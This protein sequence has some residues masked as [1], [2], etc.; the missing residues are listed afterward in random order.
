MSWVQ[1]LLKLVI[2]MIMVLNFV[3][4][5]CF[6]ISCLIEEVVDCLLI[7]IGL[8]NPIEFHGSFCSGLISMSIPK[9]LSLNLRFFKITIKDSQLL[10]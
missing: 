7:F 3:H 8:K 5:P 6:I 4:K 1:I 10:V 2:K 9:Q